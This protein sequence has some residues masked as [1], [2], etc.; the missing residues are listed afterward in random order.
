MSNL[1]NSILKRWNKVIKFNRVVTDIPLGNVL[2]KIGRSKY[3]EAYSVIA[4]GGGGSL[5]NNTVARPYTNSKSAILDSISD[6]KK[7]IELDLAVTSDGY[8][9]AVHCWSEIKSISRYN[10]IDR[11]ILH[12]EEPLSYSEVKNIDVGNESTPLC[13][14]EINQIF[15]E[16]QDLILV[17]DKIKDISLL[18]NEFNYVD[19]LIVEV[20]DVNSYE[21]AYRLGVKNIVFNIDIRIRKIVDWVLKNKIKAVSF[22]AK[23]VKNHKRAYENSIKLMGCGVVSLAYS[24]NDDEFIKNNINK[25][26]SAFYTDYW[27]LKK[28]EC[29]FQGG[30][31]TY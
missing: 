12:N 1:V 28:K 8:I 5:N 27:S 7:L 6:G 31:I 18:V 29:L 26:A 13:I 17:T 4:H 15:L 19:R 14:N 10:G 11:Q 16:N 30:S 2:Y 3:G 9:V 24:S 25:T 21:L 23:E 20:F 22:S